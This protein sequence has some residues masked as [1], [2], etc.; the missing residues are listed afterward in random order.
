MQIL[1]ISSLP[2][3]SINKP[4]SPRIY[5]LCKELSKRH[6]IFFMSP[7]SKQQLIEALGSESE[8]NEI[9]SKIITFENPPKPT[10]LCR[11]AHSILRTPNHITKWR[12]P[13]YFFNTKQLVTRTISELSPDAIIGHCAGAIQYISKT[14]LPTIVDLVDSVAL[15]NSR[16]Q[17]PSNNI[18]RKII[19]TI[20][21]FA[22]NYYERKLSKIGKHCTFVSQ[23]DCDWANKVSRIKNSQ[24]ITNGINTNYFAKVA[25]NPYSTQIVFIGV[26]NYAPNEDA[27]IWFGSNIFSKIT[28]KYQELSFNVV[29][30]SPTPEVLQ[31]S[32][33][34]NINVTGTV[35]DVR[36]YLNKALC[37]VCPMRL[38]SGLKNKILQ[39][40]STGIPVISTSAGADGLDIIPDTHYLLANSEN[41]FLAQVER[42]IENPA[43]GEKI[44]ENSYNLVNSKYSWVTQALKLENLLT[45]KE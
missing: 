12:Y 24:I 15:F 19:A 32:K 39:A 1:V 35:D 7:F 20:D 11:V 38:G 16:K 41:E 10:F 23:L 9:F 6:E 31:L 4:G 26:M 22:T 2:P 17:Q 34:Q 8:L 13:K 3:I 29:G 37:F 33:T 42:L 28:S 44:I 25:W 36:P 5:C 40:F 30:A 18:I 27:A 45:H 21:I 43:L 14:S